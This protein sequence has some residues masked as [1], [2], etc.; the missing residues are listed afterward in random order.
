MRDPRSQWR[1][2]ARG[3]ARAILAE[4]DGTYSTLY[5]CAPV[6]LRVRYRKCLHNTF[7]ISRGQDAPRPIVRAMKTSGDNSK[8]IR[9]APRYITFG[10][11]AVQPPC[12]YP[13]Y[14]SSLDPSACPS[15][16]SNPLFGSRESPIVIAFASSLLGSYPGYHNRAVDVSGITTRGFRGDV[17][18]LFIYPSWILSL[19]FSF[20]VINLCPFGRQECRYHNRVLRCNTCQHSHSYQL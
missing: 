19:P 9:A 10:V 4:D 5:C 20:L 8:E 12:S 3:H 7:C 2:D 1:T 11:P 17:L 6:P 15:P 14:S 18:R 16:G 13:S